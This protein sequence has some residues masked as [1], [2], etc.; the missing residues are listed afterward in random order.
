MATQR[1]ASQ[2]IAFTGALGEPLAA[3]IDW[4]KG[5]T[6][7][8]AIFAHC[9]TCSKDFFASRRISH[10]LTAHGFAVLR[11]DFTGLGSSDGEFG[12]TN[13]SSNA[14]DV[15]A[16]AD[17]LAQTHQAPSLLVGH[18]FGGAAVLAAAPEIPAVQAVAT[19]AAPASADHVLHVIKGG[20]GAIRER[21]EA[22][23]DIGGRPF[24]IK[25]QFLDDLG[26]TQLT[27]RIAKLHAALLI[28]HAPADQQ[29]GI[30]NAEQI[31]MAAR[32][33]KSFVSLD[34]ADHLLSQHADSIYVADVISA[35]ASRYVPR[36]TKQ[37]QDEGHV[38]VAESG[39]GAYHLEINA[40]GH[41]LSADEPEDV[42][43]TNRGATPYDLLSAALG[44]CTTITLRMYATRKKLA[45]T[46]IETRV[47]HSKRHATDSQ[48][49]AAERATKVDHF[50]RE[51]LI[52][53][54]LD[55]AQ[56][57]RMLQIAD[58]CPVHKTLERSSK[59]ES[60]LV[61]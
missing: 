36:E 38:I 58:L 44:A 22:E 32:H 10:A 1:P 29:V 31:Y 26:G 17:W 43:G 27:D 7:A 19:I 28:M 46:N 56:R 13:F 45:V 60:K 21:G 5:P 53:G 37:L 23:V 40:S 9:F 59:V 57:E 54:D 18:S 61:E 47:S 42:G 4:P 25:R 16:A 20:V 34:G 12:N 24:T 35:W 33:P 14:A 39:E 49:V 48:D 2:K 8:F 15:V 6:Q 41:A 30:E 52:E 11:F 55:A 3:A 50:Q 51:I